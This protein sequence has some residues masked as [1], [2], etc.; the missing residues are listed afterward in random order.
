M[1]LNGCGGNI[2]ARYARVIQVL[3]LFQL[4]TTVTGGEDYR[5]YG[6]K[7]VSSPQEKSIGLNFDLNQIT[8]K[9]IQT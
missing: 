8:F 5:F 6:M 3:K 7:S 9:D 2:T 1:V 4:F